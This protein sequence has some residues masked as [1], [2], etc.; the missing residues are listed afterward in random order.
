MPLDRDR[1]I[2]RTNRFL[3]EENIIHCVT[4]YT[5]GMSVQK[6]SKVTKTAWLDIGEFPK[7]NFESYQYRVKPEST[8]V[9]PDPTTPPAQSGE[10]KEAVA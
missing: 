10:L 4:A 2:P 5:M 8:T 3:A 7:W 9:S 1:F 6:Q